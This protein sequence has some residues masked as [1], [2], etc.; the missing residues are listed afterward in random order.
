M[1]ESV[2]RNFLLEIRATPSRPV[3]LRLSILNAGDEGIEPS[4]AR[5]ECAVLPLN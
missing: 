1:K 5:L 3:G 4:L 2:T